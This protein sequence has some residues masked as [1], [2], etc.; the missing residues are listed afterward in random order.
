MK[1]ISILLVFMMAF[2]TL[3]LKANDKNPKNIK[4]TQWLTS[5]IY[6]MLADESIP[7]NIRGAKAELRIILAEDGNYR[8]LSVDSN[9]DN[10]RDFLKDG[11]D[12]DVIAKGRT[13][14]VYVIPIEIA[15]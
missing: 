15:E 7:D 9:N 11:I 3:T 14:V 1:K 13:N 2:S 6:Q 5:Q 10:L 8:I 12:L 4:E